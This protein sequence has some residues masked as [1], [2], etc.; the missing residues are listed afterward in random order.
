M[1]NAT[2]KMFVATAKCEMLVGHL[3]TPC[4]GLYRIT[5]L[6]HT[7]SAI[8]AAAATNAKCNTSHRCELHYVLS[9][10]ALCLL[11]NHT[12][13]RPLIVCN[14]RETSCHVCVCARE[15][16][17]PLSAGSDAAWDVH[18]LCDRRLGV[19]SPHPT[20]KS[21]SFRACVHVAAC[22]NPRRRRH[23]RPLMCDFPY[24]FTMCV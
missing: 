13:R 10:Y 19:P 11:T 7:R 15:R 14:V 21:D 3:A 8:A 6:W 2:C 18:P 22:Q 4:R 5:A 12:Y 23:R 1:C 16:C 20:G 24:E 9:H 17:L